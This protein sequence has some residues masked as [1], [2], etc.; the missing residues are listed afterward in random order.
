MRRIVFT[1]ITLFAF[2]TQSALAQ[3]PAGNLPSGP[4]GLEEGRTSEYVMRKFSGERLIPIRMLGGVRNPGTYY[5]PIGTDMVTL[6]S[7][8][9]GIAQGAD[10]EQIQYRPWAGKKTR[11]LDLQDAL[12]EPL[13]YNPTMEPNDVLYVA[14]SK[15]V[16]SNNTMII[17][18]A[19]ASVI[20]IGTGVILIRSQT[21]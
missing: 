1:C 21:K 7:L 5:V 11:V 2:S 16:L 3:G 15:P 19:I 9:G 10:S 12:D 14:E 8:S 4:L 17:L 6:L 18:S 13:K 20:A